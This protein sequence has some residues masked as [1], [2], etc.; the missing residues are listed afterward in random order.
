[1][2]NAA[3]AY[4]IVTFF[5]VLAVLIVTGVLIF[6]ARRIRK[7]QTFI[8]FKR[9]RDEMYAG[10]ALLAVGIALVVTLIFTLFIGH[11]KISPDNYPRLL[12][13]IRMVFVVLS[14]LCALGILASLKRGELRQ[15]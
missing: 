4:Y 3:A 1:M 2:D 5:S 14:L 13:G 7:E 8:G 12:S 9:S 11:A 10:Y 6:L 15:T